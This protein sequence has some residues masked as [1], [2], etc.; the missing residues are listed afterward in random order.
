[1]VQ[2]LLGGTTR[3][4]EHT[5]ASELKDATLQEML[6][7]EQYLTTSEPHAA[8]LTPGRKGKHI[9]ARGRMH[10]PRLS[11]TPLCV[12]L[13]LNALGDANGNGQ[14]GGSLN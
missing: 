13:K 5:E 14:R 3:L 6:A 12:L 9:L 10:W 11:A 2:P 4:N 1:M 7:F 8:V